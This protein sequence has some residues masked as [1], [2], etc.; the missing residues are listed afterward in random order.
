MTAPIDIAAPITAFAPATDKSFS[1]L[2]P[3]SPRVYGGVNWEGLK[4][5]YLKEVR[6]F[7]KVGMQTVAS[8]VITV[9]LYMLVFVVATKG[10]SPRGGRYS[11]SRSLSP[12]D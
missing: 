8:P 12:Q 11:V 3:V 4:T 10:R 6:R 2:T 9:L 7:W 5:L 1:R